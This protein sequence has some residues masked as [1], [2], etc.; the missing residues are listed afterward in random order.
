MVACFSSGMS[1]DQTRTR[2]GQLQPAVP[3]SG[4]DLNPSRSDAPRDA[5]T[6]QQP[7]TIEVLVRLASKRTSARSLSI[8]QHTAAAE[9]D[10]AGRSVAEAVTRK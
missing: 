3:S 1:W 5:I 8:A 9:S 2:R 7:P 10:G 6:E 4:S